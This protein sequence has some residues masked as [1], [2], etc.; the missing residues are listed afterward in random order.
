[1]TWLGLVGGPI[2]MI[3]GILAI[4]NVIPARGTVQSLGGLLEAL[5]ELSLSIY[6]IAAGFRASSP[7]FTDMVTKLPDSDTAVRPHSI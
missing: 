4:L 1:M 6:C 2:L 5:W 7:V 3:T